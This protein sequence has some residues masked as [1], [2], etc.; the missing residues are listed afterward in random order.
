MEA[1]AKALVAFQAEARNV[2]PNQ[3]GKIRLKDGGSYSYEYADL[4]SVL[5]EIK[6]LLKQH[7]L[8]ILQMPTTS[9]TGGE[10][11]VRTLIV[12]TSGETLDAGTLFLPLTQHTPQ[13]AGSCVSYARRYVLGSLAAIATEHDDDAQ[14]HQPMPSQTNPSPADKSHSN[15]TV[16]SAFDKPLGFGKNKDRTWREMTEGS[17]GGERHSYLIWLV[18]NVDPA[19]DKYA[20][21]RSDRAQKCLAIY[22]KRADEEA[23]KE[24]KEEDL[25]DDGAGAF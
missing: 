3:T 5:A 1:I 8:A 13:G 14:S 19:K 23:S 18:G 7:G 10:I 17:I 11:G 12:H 22:G 15:P 2:A 6:P 9:D 20:K 25:P 16:G 24:Q 21:E 4:P